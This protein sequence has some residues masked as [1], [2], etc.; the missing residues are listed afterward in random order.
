MSGGLDKPELFFHMR[1]RPTRRLRVSSPAESPHY[2][3]IFAGFRHRPATLFTLD[4][5]WHVV[6]S[7]SLERVRCARHPANPLL[8]FF[9]LI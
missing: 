4:I 3:F 1:L 7:I 8:A 9:T 6:Y 5:K 2:H